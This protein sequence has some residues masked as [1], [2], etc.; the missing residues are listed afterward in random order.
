[1]NLDP[2]RRFALF[3][4]EQAIILGQELT[5][6]L[7]GGGGDKAREAQHRN[8]RLHASGRAKN[9]LQSHCAPDSNT[10]R[11]LST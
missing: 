1:M 5:D 8:Q 2:I 7:A 11:G 4:E 6:D 3:I 9:V 10:A